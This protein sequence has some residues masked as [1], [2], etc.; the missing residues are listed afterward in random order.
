MTPTTLAPTT[1]VVQSFTIYTPTRL[2][3]GADQLEAFAQ[4]TA[5][6]GN[7]AFVM[8]GGGTVERFGYLQQLSDGLDAVGVSTV[9]FAGV[10]ANPDAATINRAAARAR[11][12]GADRR[13][14]HDGRHRLRGHADCGHLEPPGVREVDTDG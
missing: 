10:E 9:Q 3:F 1:S 14:P 5:R 12:N 11:E 4:A 8:T 7:K 2:F 13:S 6:V